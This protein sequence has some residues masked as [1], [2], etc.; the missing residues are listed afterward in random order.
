M[1]LIITTVKSKYR[2][3]ADVQFIVVQIHRHEAVRSTTN[4]RNFNSKARMKLNCTA[5]MARIR[6]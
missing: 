6:H 3:N 5:E 2:N 4:S 1:I